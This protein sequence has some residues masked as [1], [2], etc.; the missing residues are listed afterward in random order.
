MQIRFI[1][2]SLKRLCPIHEWTG[3]Q[4]VEGSPIIG[5]PVVDTKTWLGWILKALKDY[6]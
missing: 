5:S 4:R 1:S 3:R 2:L 6:N